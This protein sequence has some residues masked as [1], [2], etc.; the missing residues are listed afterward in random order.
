MVF[1]MTIVKNNV[2]ISAYF[3][4][5][6]ISSLNAKINEILGKSFYASFLIFYVTFYHYFCGVVELSFKM[7]LIWLLM[8]MTHKYSNIF[9]E[10]L[11]WIIEDNLQRP[12]HFLKTNFIIQ[13][14]FRKHNLINRF[15]IRQF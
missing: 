2:E 3:N 14:N 13:S 6:L 15:M 9:I 4:S 12:N 8:Y 10:A 5:H 1:C 7:I 11:C